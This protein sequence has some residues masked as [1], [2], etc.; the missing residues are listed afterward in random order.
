M[1]TTRLE[2]EKVKT[3]AET[4]R[5]ER[6]VKYKEEIQLL[7]LE[8]ERKLEDVQENADKKLKQHLAIRDK[9]VSELMLRVKSSGAE[10]LKA[11][12]EKRTIEE[13]V[14]RLKYTGK[15]LIVKIKHEG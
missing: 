4:S 9:E 13:E 11:Q 1:Y 8:T 10:L 5:K 14:E 3:A 2:C 12:Q 7:R 15:R 6:E